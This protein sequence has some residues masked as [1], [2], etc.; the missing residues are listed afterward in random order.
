MR[1]W[2]RRQDRD[3][4]RALNRVDGSNMAGSACSRGAAR[5]STLMGSSAMP[6]SFSL[7]CSPI[8]AFERAQDLREPHIADPC[9]NE[10]VWGADT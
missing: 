2:S 10:T 9:V 5:S 4:E 3:R 1:F 6:G 7:L 8:L